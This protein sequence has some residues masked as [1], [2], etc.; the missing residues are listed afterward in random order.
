MS[1]FS[2]DQ[3]AIR[4]MQKIKD[5]PSMASMIEREPELEP[6]QHLG[7]KLPWWENLKSEDR[8]RHFS[9]ELE[10]LLSKRL[11]SFQ[12][13][14][15]SVIAVAIHVQESLM[16]TG[17]FDSV[18]RVW[19]LQRDSCLKAVKEHKGCI[20]AIVCIPHLR[21]F[22]SASSD[23]HIIVWSLSTFKPLGNYESGHAGGISAMC[24]S[25]E[26]DRLWTSGYDGQICCWA[27]QENGSLELLGL[28]Y[29]AKVGKF[30]QVNAMVM[31]TD[32]SFLC[33]AHQDASIKL[34]RPGG[35]GLVTQLEGHRL[36]VQSLCLSQDDR[37]LYSGGSDNTIRAWKLGS[38][39]KCVHVVESLE[40]AVMN[41]KLSSSGAA[42]I[43]TCLRD[44]VVW[45][46]ATWKIVKKFA[47]HKSEIYSLFLYPNSNIF[48]TGSMDK[49]LKFW[50]MD[51][52]FL[53]LKTIEGH[54]DS[55]RCLLLVPPKNCLVSA[56]YDNTIRVWDLDTKNCLATLEGHLACVTDLAYTE[57]SD[58]LFSASKDGSIRVWSF[59]H[60]KLL[61]SYI[62]QEE[63][64]PVIKISLLP[65]QQLLLSAQKHPDIRVWDVNS[66]AVK[67]LL[68]GHSM[69]V[70]SLVVSA[71]QKFAYSGG[72]DLE[73]LV[74][75]L[76][77]LK[78]VR[79]FGKEVHTKTITAM[80]IDAESK[81]LVSG[82]QDRSIKVWNLDEFS[83]LHSLT[84]HKDVI[85]SL[86]FSKNSE[87]LYSS[88]LD[89]FFKIWELET[90]KS[91]TSIGNSKSPI[92][93]VVLDPTETKIYWASADCSVKMLSIDEDVSESK[94]EGHSGKIHDMSLATEQDRANLIT[95]SEDKT[96]RI[97]DLDSVN[98]RAVI[99]T[100]Q[101]I[102]CHELSKANLM[103]CGAE[104]SK[105]RIYDPYSMENN[106]K[107]SSNNFFNGQHDDIITC[108][109]LSQDEE[110]LITGSAKNDQIIR[111]WSVKQQN[112]LFEL[113]SLGGSVMKLRLSQDKAR[114][115]AASKN[116]VVKIYDLDK[117]QELSSLKGHKGSV[118][119]IALSHD[120]KFLYSGGA[121]HT[122]KAWNLE[123]ES[124]M[125][126]YKEHTD[127]VICLLY[128]PT[129]QHLISSGKDRHINIYLTIDGQMIYRI[130]TRDTDISCMTLSLEKKT[131]FGGGA[132]HLNSFNFYPF[133]DLSELD[134]I[135]L[136]ALNHYL[137]AD[138][139][140][141]KSKELKNFIDALKLKGNLYYTQRVN[142]ILFLANLPFTQI[143]RYALNIFKYPKFVFTY[144]DDLLYRTLVDPD[145]RNN[146]L[147][148]VCDYLID[149]PKEIYLH[150][151]T[152]VEMMKLYNNIKIQKL[153]TVLF[154]TSIKGQEGSQLIVK[155]ALKLDPIMK[156][157]NY[158]DTIPRSLNLTMIENESKLE[159]IDYRI[160]KFPLNM[161]NGTEFSLI[162][163]KGLARCQKDVVLSDMKHIINY[164]WYKLKRVILI[165]ALAFAILVVLSTAYLVF[166]ES[167]FVLFLLCLILNILFIF[168]EITCARGDFRSFFS[169]GF[170]WLDA[171]LFPLNI[172]TLIITQVN[173]KNKEIVIAVDIFVYMFRGLT[174]LRVF[175]G[176]RYLVAMILRVF[177]S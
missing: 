43:S 67:S 50:N 97:W 99:P 54:I 109:C 20:N 70:F 167:N 87:K 8:K 148:T 153:L 83:L 22:V 124:V 145:K 77:A 56:G 37:F 116:S 88:S 174:F 73:I 60:F 161:H 17:G 143:L 175:D 33:L 158:I 115:Y 91:I 141:D 40:S 80:A 171:L 15:G 120:D 75:D 21:C 162:F 126:T 58:I 102:F 110:L 100:K 19:D 166:Y 44:V 25:Q 5:E 114:L 90:V 32:Q 93:Q 157:T 63:S 177:R 65:A 135:S 82:S 84:D 59:T 168:F 155:G 144:E 35:Q 64:P 23:S 49:T 41:L 24:V 48:L 81:F 2:L 122:I 123:D 74:W 137:Q 113:P 12:G 42:L 107:N 169:R 10:M 156:P 11:D 30:V 78:L 57:I 7:P 1:S 165:H 4:Y 147:N 121:D 69:P 39:M 104:D 103:Y 146:H 85:T 106:S 27:V 71:H 72:E 76:R 86:V 96:I 18:I 31:S 140:S 53:L 61:G 52:D 46:V 108:V 98:C 101:V 92:N 139:S 131:L 160:T 150:Q 117:R 55:V 159:E 134:N 16:I 118:N 29:D 66:R 152:V 128:A 142:P 62:S 138:T 79:R 163:F 133:Q 172:A 9:D 26:M 125:E 34:V 173:V 6:A 149:N 95:S 170:N 68:K 51:E 28:A 154:N 176:T 151:S 127:E 136:E 111:V 47:A 45:D 13:H 105:V 89:G 164:K 112:I 129:N 14:L 36:A 94:I 38:T 3:T 130:K 132:K 119:D